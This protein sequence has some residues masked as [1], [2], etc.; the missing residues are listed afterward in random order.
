MKKIL[1]F[2]FLLTVSVSAQAIQTGTLT[3]V[4]T[5]DV[6]LNGLYKW[7]SIVLVDTGA[8]YTDTVNF[9]VADRDSTY[10][11]K[12]GA[13]KQSDKV[14]YPEA[15]T[16]NGTNKWLIYEPQIEWLR[17]EKADTS[18]GGG[19]DISYLIEGKRGR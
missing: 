16:S 10:W 4:D 5:V 6:D 13:I 15:T 7:V 3:D 19:S 12:V 14:F 17:I 9:Y 1:L 11:A 18:S 8:T 2:M